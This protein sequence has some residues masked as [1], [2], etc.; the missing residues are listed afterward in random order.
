MEGA[1]SAVRDDVSY[2]KVVLGAGKAQ[3]FEPADVVGAIVDHSHLEGEDVRHVR[4]LER[5]SFA[6]VPEARAKDVV[7]SVTGKKVRGV[8]LQLELARR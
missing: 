1:A 8:E 5:F 2:T 7:G 3:G 6:Q 4:V